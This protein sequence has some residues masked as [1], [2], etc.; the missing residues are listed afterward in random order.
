MWNKSIDIDIIS[1]FHQ[2]RLDR[3][4]PVRCNEILYLNEKKLC[5]I[6]ISNLIFIGNVELFHYLRMNAFICLTYIIINIHTE[7][8]VLEFL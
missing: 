1:R 6:D 8:K 3:L 2:V 4:E 5:N 7:K